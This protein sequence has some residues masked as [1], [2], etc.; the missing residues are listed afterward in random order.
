M[1][2]CDDH[3]QLIDHLVQLEHMKSTGQPISLEIPFALNICEKAIQELDLQ[4]NR[5]NRSSGVEYFRERRLFLTRVL[6]LIYAIIGYYQKTVELT[7]KIDDFDMARIYANKPTQQAAKKKLWLM[8]SKRLLE[9]KS[10][11]DSKQPGTHNKDSDFQIREAMEV[12][13]STNVIK[14]E[15]VLN[16]FP[17]TTDNIKDMREQI[18]ACID[19]YQAKIKKMHSQ[20]EKNTYNTNR[21]RK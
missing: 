9:L 18:V 21:L 7:L 15:E 19:D 8:I 6:A 11:R 4:M 13:R 2:D 12:I 17:D 5:I 10:I 14:L 20:I 16:L 3:S 1:L